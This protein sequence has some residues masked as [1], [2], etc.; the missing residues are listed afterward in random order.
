M[1]KYEPHPIARLFPPKTPEER[2]EMKE[3]MLER[4]ARGLDPLVIPTFLYEGRILDGRHR[5]EV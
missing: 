2:A 3:D 5:D 1:T 4:M